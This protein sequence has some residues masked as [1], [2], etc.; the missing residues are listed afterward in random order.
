MSTH[1]DLTAR[2]RLAAA[3][4]EERTRLRALQRHERLIRERERARVLVHML[5]VEQRYD[6]TG[7]APGATL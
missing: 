3:H 7:F 5:P 6:E 1:R 2:E 4:E